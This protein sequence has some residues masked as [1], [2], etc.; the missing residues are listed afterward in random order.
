[1]G[2]SNLDGFGRCLL[3]DFHDVIRGGLPAF[4]CFNLVAIIPVGC[5][6]TSLCN[7]L[8]DD[9]LAFCMEEVNT[10]ALVRGIF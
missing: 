8:R 9:M 4:L 2:T 1:L 5:V 6:S 3:E 7:G 10:E